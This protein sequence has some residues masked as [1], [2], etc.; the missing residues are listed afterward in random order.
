ME[1]A[2]DYARLLA[3][4]LGSDLKS[5]VLYGSVAR[6]DAQA[7]TDIDLF[8]IAENLPERR[9]P[10]QRLSMEVEDL[11]EPR[12][13]ALRREGR[14]IDFSPILETPAEARRLRPLYLDMTQD[15]VVLHDPEGLF[16]DIVARMRQKLA[17]YGARRLQLGNVRYWDLKPDYRWGERISFDE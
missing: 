15:A 4:R 7:N 5:V 17:K 3:E 13:A 9:A 16:E 2:R 10:R 12:L 6:G 8:V 1:L 11:L 14:I